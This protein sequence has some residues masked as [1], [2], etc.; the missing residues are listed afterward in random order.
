LQE[1]LQ[2]RNQIF[3]FDETNRAAHPIST[4]LN[5]LNRQK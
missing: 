1:D 2:E 4:V 5:L 3:L